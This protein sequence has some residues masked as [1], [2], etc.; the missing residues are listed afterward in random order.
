[1]KIHREE[2]QQQ[3]EELPIELFYAGCK[4]PETK[5]KY[6]RTLNKILCDVL[7]DVL[8]GTF[9]QRANQ[10]VSY[11][12]E[13]PKW[14]QGV[15]LQLSE[16]L[17]KRTELSPDHADYLNPTSVNNY[18]KPL[19]KLLDMND[20]P[21]S[22]KRIYATF[23]ELDNVS[24]SRGYTLQEIQKLLQHANGAIDRAIILIA[25]S[26]GIRVGGFE[27]KWK[28][29]V[30]VYQV[31]E[32]ITFD[33]TESQEKQAEIV[34]AMISIYND[35][36]QKYPAFITPEAYDA[37]LNYKMEWIKEVG[38]E[39]KPDEPIF[40]REGI[41]PIPAKPTA[42]KQRMER[43]LGRSGIRMP[44]VTGKRRHDVP[45]MN[46]FRRF[47]NKTC[48]ET[49]SKDSPLA[50]LIK[51]EYLMGHSGLVKTNKNYFK[52]QISELIE[53]YLSVV[54]NL[55]ISNEKRLRLENKKKT[56]KIEKLEQQQKEI[57][58]LKLE[59]K[60][61]DIKNKI[62]DALKKRFI[63]WAEE[64]PDKANAIQIA[65][66][67]LGKMDIDDIVEHLISKHDGD[68]GEYLER[69][70]LSNISVKDE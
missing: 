1:M 23:P 62:S 63:E 24:E 46:G 52:T 37:L 16:K 35:S 6:T 49:T 58:N 4:S 67:G 29:I 32:K 53:E 14:I 28:D 36:N 21:V 26:S 20:I 39:P 5:K 9:E 40:K 55:T 17:R 43:I 25:S 13:N 12:Q 15:L 3:R 22:W 18:F 8:E 10:L 11:S 59:V 44:L 30:P 19:R 61:I 2:L 54:P 51:K 41:L 48:N 31:D 57:E 65:K 50:S 38:R 45:V 33:I 7:E 69:I 66:T 64:N 27:L 60:R 34:C 47:W 56:E 68:I 42:I 70:S